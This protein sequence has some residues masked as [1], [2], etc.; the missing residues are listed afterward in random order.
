MA[1]AVIECFEVIKV[2]H[3]QRQPA[4]RYVF[5]FA[6]FQAFDNYPLEMASVGHAGQR[7]L[8]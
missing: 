5:R 6:V 1:V 8:F 4:G 3:H 2:D 7:I